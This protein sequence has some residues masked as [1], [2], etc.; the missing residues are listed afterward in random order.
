MLR[1]KKSW[2]EKLADNKGFPKV[3]K[4]DH[5]KSKRWGTGTFVIPAPME[6]DELMRRVPKGKLTTIDELRKVIAR[7]H[8]ATMACPITTG[9]FAWIAAHAAAEAAAKGKKRITPFWRTLKSKGE[10]NPKYPG[11]ITELTRK[12]SG[13]GHQVI[14]KGKRFFAENFEANLVPFGLV[15]TGLSQKS[16][17]RRIS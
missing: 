7:K 1:P 13:E 4:I 9:I 12:L 11:G 17:S 15:A 3:C 6:V 8:Q 16:K 10:L 14:Q 2:E 5:T